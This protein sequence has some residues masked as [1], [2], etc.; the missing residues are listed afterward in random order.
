MI[1]NIEVLDGLRQ[2][3][4]V[5]CKELLVYYVAK[6]NRI[7]CLRYPI[8]DELMY[9]WDICPKNSQRA[10]TVY[11]AWN[12]EC[13]KRTSCIGTNKIFDLN[14]SRIR[15]II[16]DLISC[17][18]EISVINELNIPGTAFCDIEVDVND[19]GFPEA[20]D[21]NMPVNSI[22]WVF[23]DKVIVLGRAPLSS[24]QIEKI[25]IDVR[26]YCKRFETDYKF[27]YVYYDDERR[28]LYDFFDK[29]VKVTPCITGWNFFGYD[30]PYLWNRCKKDFINIDILQILSRPSNP[31]SILNTIHPGTISYTPRTNKGHNERLTL[32]S[33]IMMYDYMEVYAKWDRVISPKETNQ[34]DWVADRALG[35]KKVQH[36]LGFK[37]FWRQKPDEYIFYNAIDSIL[38]REIDNKL[39]TS[40]AFFSLANLLHVPA[41]IA[42]SPVRSLEAVQTDYLYRD[43]KVF[44]S[45]RGQK[46]REDS[47]SYEGAFVYEPI[48]GVYWNIIALDFASLY[49]TTIRQ[50]NI[51]PDTFIVKD[52]S[53]SKAADEIKTISGAT[54][55]R[56]VEGF[57]PHILTD[58]YA[59]RKAYKKEML[60]AEKESGDLQ[61]IFERRFGNNI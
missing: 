37:E 11:K 40:K 60:I 56:N 48:A 46:E 51:S 58:F 16:C 7:Q 12:G 38:V 28:M 39:K 43:M 42:F 19:D 14:E 57:I 55:K 8:P 25:K 23:N 59:Q 45:K 20:A 53:R 15:E 17:Y 18:P 29:Y 13:V 31:S 47:D 1:V 35:I 32:P 26:E 5:P 54:Y 10:D 27:E 49:P 41:L 36:D 34:L 44:P 4:G 9:N 22:S 52:K 61:E 50:F 33:H 2:G 30:Y 24:A 3:T 6:D 21:A